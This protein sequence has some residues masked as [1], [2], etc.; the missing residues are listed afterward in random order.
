[1]R[2]GV[3]RND[4]EAGIDQRLDVRREPAAARSPAVHEIH[5]WPVTPRQPHDP[6]TLDFHLERLST[7]QD[8][9]HRGRQP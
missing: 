9:A 3:E 5:R 8:S 4:A 7:I 6:L 1:V 2:D